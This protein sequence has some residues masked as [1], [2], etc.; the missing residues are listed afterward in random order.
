MRIADITPYEKNAK[1]LTKKQKG[2]V[3]DYVKT[4][5]GTQAVINNY[6]IKSIN[7]VDVAKSIASENLTKPY[8]LEEVKKEEKKIADM[9]PDELLGERHLELLN[10][11][12][13][14]VTYRANG[15]KEYELIDQP[16]T[17]AV[18]KGLD[19]AY[20]IKS[21]Y[22]PEKSVNLNFDITAEAEIKA[23]EIITRYLNG[24]TGNF[25]K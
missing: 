13:V 17:Q 6:K 25:T 1:K 5:N 23:N 12:E 16:D 21:S 11:R 9:L 7:K 22:A 14:F 20:K 15:Q 19:M 24:D 10:K 2:F 8:I 4:G 18:S 3:K